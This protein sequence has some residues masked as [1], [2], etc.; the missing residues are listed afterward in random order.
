MSPKP[1]I[2]LLSPYP[3]GAA[4]SQRF[5]YEHYLEEEKEVTHAPFWS[6][7]SWNRLYDSGNWGHKIAGLMG[8]FLRRLL[9]LRHL[10]RYECV[11]IH[12]EATPLGPPI[13]EWLIAKVWRKP[14]IYD[15]DDAIWL[16]NTSRENRW[17][18]WLKWH[19]KVKWICRWSR[20]VSCGNTYLA[21]Y[22]REYARDVRVIPTVV[23]TRHAHNRLKDQRQGRVVVGWT[24]SHSTLPY[25]QPLLPVLQE[26][27]RELEF[28][29]VVIA[30]KDPQLAL[31]HYRFV[32]WNKATEIDDLLQL[33]IGLMPLEDSAWTRGKCGFKAIQYMALGIP[34]LVS[35]VGV[36]PQIVTQGEQGF[37]CVQPADWKRYL[38][39]LIQD[40]DLRSR[41]GQAGRAR[42][43]EKYSVAATRPAFQQL[44]QDAS[45]SRR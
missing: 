30:N 38:R 24:G 34:A 8:G 10:H 29:T 33:H 21:A 25:L 6:A 4:P 11:Y 9:L 20:I 40:A 16:P 17:V 35:P 26:L 43:Q 12:R 23:D 32:P 15:F 41:L 3:W 22:A 42:V 1:S 5:R 39:Q 14:I 45:S 19:G 31:Q 37:H 2:L 18:A 36:N 44:L 7:K 28:E 13:F 27:E